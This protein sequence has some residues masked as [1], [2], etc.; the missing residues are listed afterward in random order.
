VDKGKYVTVT[1][2][3]LGS[4]AYYIHTNC[5]QVMLSGVSCSETEVALVMQA[6]YQIWLLEFHFFFFCGGRGESVNFF[7][8]AIRIN[9]FY[10]LI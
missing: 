5:P 3:T 9:I 6:V 10:G 8:L 4:S 1:K 7:L 2:G